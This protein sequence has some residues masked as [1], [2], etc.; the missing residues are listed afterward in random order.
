MDRINRPYGTNVFL[1]IKAA[2]NSVANYYAG[3]DPEVQDES[4]GH[5]WVEAPPEYNI[6]THGFFDPVSHDLAP[7]VVSQTSLDQLTVDLVRQYR[8][9]ELML[10]DSF[11]TQPDDRPG[12]S[13]TRDL[14]LPYRQALR[15]LG[16]H[17]NTADMLAAWPIRPDG[18]DP[19]SHLRGTQS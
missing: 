10:T 9:A 6:L 1:Q 19:I 5:V 13:A 15:D 3:A 17:S 8:D 4:E 18:I 14:W 16:A 7:H 11:V 2:D 12:A